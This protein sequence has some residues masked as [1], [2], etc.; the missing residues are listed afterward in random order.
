M[1]WTS[2]CY[3]VFITFLYTFL[4]WHCHKPLIPDIYN[5]DDEQFLDPA[6]FKR[7][8]KQ[9]VTHPES[10]KSV[11][12]LTT[13]AKV[14][15]W[16]PTSTVVFLFQQVPLAATELSHEKSKVSRMPCVL[17][18]RNPFAMLFYV[19]SSYFTS[20]NE[21][22]VDPGWPNST[23]C[24][25]S[26]SMQFSATRRARP[27]ARTERR[28]VTSPIPLRDVTSMATKRRDPW[29][30]VIAAWGIVIW[31]N[32]QPMSFSQTA[33]MST[34]RALEVYNPYHP[35]IYLSTSGWFLW[36]L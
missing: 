36:Q 30:R 19:S 15:W 24:L 29:Q 10:K 28:T 21:N 26:L 31:G 20:M 17:L 16:L 34:V 4:E 6:A 27:F 1:I 8:V 11:G 22:H 14:S 18:L 5:K 2:C 23:D 32:Y 9:Q 7:L 3:P 12:L 25:A 33:A 13:F 35:S